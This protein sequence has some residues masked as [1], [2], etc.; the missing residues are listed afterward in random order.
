MSDPATATEPSSA[1]V[2]VVSGPPSRAAT[3]VM[4][5]CFDSDRRLA[6]VHQ[7][8][9]ARAVRAL[10]L[11]G[12]E[13][14]LAEQRGL[15]VAEDPGDRH[16]REIARPVAVDLGRAADLGEHRGRDPHHLEQLRIPLERGEVHEHRARG[17]RDVGD[18]DAAAAAA[19]GQLP[20]QPRIDRPEQQLA[21]F[22][23][24]S[25]AALV[26]DPGELQGRRVGRDRQPGPGSKAI[27]AEHP[28]DPPAA[29]AAP[30]SAVRVSCH[31]IAVMDRP[32][33]LPIPHDG[34]LALVADPHRDEVPRRH[35]RLA[36]RDL[37]AGPDALDDL[38]GVVLH[39]AG[40]RREL[41]VLE[42][43]AGD[44]PAVVVEQDA[45][46]ARGPL[47]DGGDV[48]RHGF[49]GNDEREA[50]KD[51]PFDDS[52]VQ[53]VGTPAAGCLVAIVRLR[54]HARRPCG[55]RPV[56]GRTPPRWRSRW[57]R[58]WRRSRS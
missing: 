8:E 33:G 22:R 44:D 20:R 24:G 28:R 16:A 12:L 32:A 58:S 11:A 13:A 41:G 51:L 53:R 6:R 42:L 5:P 27:G 10:D 47:V 30:A 49:D 57:P 2:A 48:R 14:G 54:R 37:H 23:G 36:Q 3:V 46:A 21:T 26:E 31:T 4:S 43:V 17:V 29:S 38:I 19:A 15:L 7:H 50:P 9:A 25:M 39:P 40:P 56:S 35:A 55:R 45:A 52:R 18:V 34:R 1:Y